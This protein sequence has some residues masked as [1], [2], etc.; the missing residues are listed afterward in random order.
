V[1]RL[2][3]NSR[4]AAANPLTEQLCM[5]VV[6]LEYI[7]FDSALPPRVSSGNRGIDE[8]AVR[9]MAAA[10]KVILFGPSEKRPVPHIGP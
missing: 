5:D 2:P 6:I 1:D 7:I 10:W 9:P 8:L 4:H 3:A